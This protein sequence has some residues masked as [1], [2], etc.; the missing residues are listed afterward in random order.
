MDNKKKEFLQ[1]VTLAVLDR[2]GTSLMHS[3]C[4][5]LGFQLYP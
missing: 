2:R 5:D 4:L 3:I 1:Q